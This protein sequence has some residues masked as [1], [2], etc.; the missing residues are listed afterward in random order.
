MT[1]AYTIISFKNFND[2]HF[3]LANFKIIQ[4]IE[5]TGILW[6]TPSI[7]TCS[8]YYGWWLPYTLA[9]L[10]TPPPLYINNRS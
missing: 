5:W 6:H 1:L 4:Y 10:N 9:G 7:F 2:L 8:C 3:I